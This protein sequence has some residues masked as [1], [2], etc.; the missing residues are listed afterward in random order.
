[1]PVPRTLQSA[2]GQAENLF[3]ALLV[4]ALSGTPLQHPRLWV[5]LSVAAA[6]AGDGVPRGQL[7]DPLAA[8]LAVPVPEAESAL[9]DLTAAGLVDTSGRPT[10]AGA[11]VLAEVRARVAALTPRLLAG[12][13]PGELETT[14]QVLETVRANARVELA[15]S[16]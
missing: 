9:T 2:V 1:M 4:R 13:D 14:L 15:D 8:V 3:G 16:R 11:A 12:V 10:P 7:A 5:A 6:H